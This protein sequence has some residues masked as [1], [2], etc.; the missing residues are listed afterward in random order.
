MK[1]ATHSANLPQS[2]PPLV[3]LDR[4]LQIAMQLALE[5]GSFLRDQHRPTSAD[6]ACDEMISQGLAAAF[7]DDAICSRTGF[8]SN[9]GSRRMWMVD[10]LDGNSDYL[11]AGNEYSLSI[12]LAIRGEAS[13]GVVYNPVRQELYAGYRGL[14]ATWNGVPVRT[15]LATPPHRGRLLVS[16]EEWKRSVNS[17]ATYQLELTASIAYNLARVAAGREDGTISL[18]TRNPWCAC[19]GAALV[20]AAGGRVSTVDGHALF[21]DCRGGAFNGLVASGPKLH[22]HVV[23]FTSSLKACMPVRYSA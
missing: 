6:L 12:G 23:E 22:A 17:E 3:R 15:T 5:A 14:G 1:E 11:L 4:E 2:A 21:F 19:A 9:A 13:L 20:L 8:L 18:R 7:P 16:S 10:P